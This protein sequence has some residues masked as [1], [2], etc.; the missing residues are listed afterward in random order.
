[1]S[2]PNVPPSGKHQR[3]TYKLI[4]RLLGA[5][6]GSPRELLTTLV[7]DV[8][9]SDRL[10]MT[11]GRLWQ[12][13]TTNDEYELVFQV[14]EV[15]FLDGGTRRHVRDMTPMAE[16]SKQRIVILDANNEYGHRVYSLTGVGDPL[17]RPSGLL[18][19]YALAFTA[20]DHTDELRDTMV[21]IGA[22]ATTALRNMAQ[23]HRET[24]LRRDLDQAWEIQR[25]LVPDHA[26]TFRDYDIYGISIPDSVVGGDYFDYLHTPDDDDRLGIVVSDAASKG[27]P[28]A[29]QA[30]FV[31]GAVRMGISFNTKITSLIARLNAL[32]YE[33]FPLERFVSLFYCELTPS[34]N[35]LVLYANAG[36]CPPVLYHSST[37]SSTLLQP[38]GGIL[39]IVEEQYVGVENVNMQPGDV[40]VLYTDGITEAQDRN[41]TI[42]GEAR[43]QNL[44][45]QASGASSYHIAMAILEDV[46]QFASGSAY[47]DDQTLV[48]IKRQG[49]S[50]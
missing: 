35:G 45:S 25:G 20:H 6:P 8:V 7:Q 42:Y 18:Y 32:L 36:H 34:A 27:L 11:G 21:V 5:A 23:S 17:P 40:L 46:Q 26:T 12:L 14:G 41:G 50:G 39:G 13:D 10:S 44:V 38:T 24:Q 47:S 19:P 3:S 2:I 37:A 4:E 43:L 1:M 22:A 49:Q 9:D 31:S 33:T 28:A 48:V 15:E 16:L 29:V 30:L